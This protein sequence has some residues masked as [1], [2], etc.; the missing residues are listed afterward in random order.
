MFIGKRNAARKMRL[1][2]AAAGVALAIAAGPALA[3]GITLKVFGGSSLDQLAPRQT[4]AEQQAI[5]KQ[6]FDGFLAANPDVKAIEWDAQGPQGEGVQR[7]MTARLAN[8]DA[9]DEAV[10]RWTSTQE[11][12]ACMALLQAAGVAAGVCQTAE[13]RCERDPQLAHQGWLTEVTAPR[14]GTW[15]I[16][17]LPARLSRTPSHVGGLPQRGAPVYGED[18]E[19]VLGELLGYTGAEIRGFERDGVI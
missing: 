13:D 6:V 7:L 5:Q 11:R 1:A 9:L 18:N 12:Y 4:P 8:Q 17:E 3:D 15:P 16:T 14:I 2:S 10:E 19:Y